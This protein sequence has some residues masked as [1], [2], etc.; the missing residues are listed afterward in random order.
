MA[1][2]ER[3]ERMDRILPSFFFAIFVF[4]RGQWVFA[5]VKARPTPGRG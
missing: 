3:K 5:L 4:L 2:R 1:A